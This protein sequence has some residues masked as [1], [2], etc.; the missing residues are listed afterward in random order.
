[1]P[2]IVMADS[3]DTQTLIDQAARGDSQALAALMERHLPRIRRA[4]QRR[5]RPRLRPR[6]DA[7]DVVQE[8]Q[9]EALVRFDDFCRRRPM[10]FRL[11]LLRTAHQKIVDVEREHLHAARRGVARELPLPDSSSIDLGGRFLAKVPGP[12]DQAMRKE[13]AAQIRRCL[14]ALPENDR[15]ILMLRCFEGLKNHDVAAMLELNPE[16][17]KK[18]FTRA[19]LRMQDALRRAGIEGVEP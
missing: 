5:L 4:V 19:L 14:A 2:S 9:R 15:E 16:T 6:L 17:T 13:L 1:M 18:R 8:A 10:P 3:A 12:E 7:S 11:W